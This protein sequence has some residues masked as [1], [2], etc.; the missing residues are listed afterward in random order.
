MALGKTHPSVMWRV[1][2]PDRDQKLVLG[3][4]S[5]LEREKDPNYSMVTIESQTKAHE[6][7]EREGYAGAEA[8]L[9]TLNDD[10]K[11]SK[12]TRR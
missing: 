4:A 10:F 8:R 3:L 12:T 2:R 5:A 11:R 6:Y 9:K 7:F 1:E